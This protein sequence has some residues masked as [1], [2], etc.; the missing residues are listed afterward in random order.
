MYNLIRPR[1][2][3]WG[4]SLI[5]NP[6]PCLALPEYSQTWDYG[7]IAPSSAVGNVAE[8][9]RG[10]TGEFLERKHFYNEV[11]PTAMHRLDESL[12]QKES[13]SF[14]KALLQTS[15]RNEE[16]ILNHE[17]RAST[18]Y[19]IFSLEKKSIP[20]VFIALDNYCLDDDPSFLPSRD[21]TGCA[22]H[23]NLK[24]SID[25]SLKELLERQCLL[26]YWLTGQP[27]SIITVDGIKSTSLD[28]YVKNLIVRFLSSG[29]LRIYDISIPGMPGYAVL[30]IYGSQSE[31]V[32]VK[33]S[34]GLSYSW[35]AKKAFEKSILELWQCFVFLHY[36]YVTGYDITEID[37]SYHRHFLDS[38]KYSTFTTFSNSLCNTELNVSDYISQ[39]ATDRMSAEPCLEG[40]TK[41][42]YLY[43]NSE[44]IKSKIIW[45]TKI[46][47]PDL[48]LHMDFSNRVNHANAIS[49]DFTT[50]ISERKS[51]MVPF[52]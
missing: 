6:Q 7:R 22:A 29:D 46:L 4:A 1:I 38:N 44:R 15:E 12:D 8:S 47:S 51:Q 14:V 9:I 32:R 31:G 16:S 10:A 17:F 42:V 18:V 39:P 48:F 20:S 3:S 49:E 52:P 45:Y 34:A 37:D 13:Q 30:S 28:S 26:R 11:V 43:V 41:N 23:V 27:N 33:Y 21:T 36:F 19:N 5:S 50:V 2:S 25:S 35:S 40:L 24:K